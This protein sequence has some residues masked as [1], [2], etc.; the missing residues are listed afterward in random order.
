MNKATAGN[1]PPHKVAVAVE[2]EAVTPG[3]VAMAA[4]GA[5]LTGLHPVPLDTPEGPPTEDLL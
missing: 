4:L 5:T 2:A 3:L 1:V